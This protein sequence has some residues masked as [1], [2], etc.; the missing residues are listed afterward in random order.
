MNKAFL[1]FF[2]CTISLLTSAQVYNLIVITTDGLRWQEV[3][4]GMDSSLAKNPKYNQRDSAFIFKKYWAESS[5]ERRKKLMP[6][7]WST[8]YESGSIYGNR[9]YQNFVNNK[10][11]YW[12]SYPGYSE[13]FT[14]T[15][16]TSINSN[17][18]PPNHLENLLEFLHK[19]PKYKGKVAAFGAWNAFDRILNQERSGFPVFSAFDSIGGKNPTRN[20]TLINSMM[21]Q[22]YRPF[23]DGEV[24]DVFTHFAAFEYLKTKKPKI[25][26]IAYGDTDEWAHH[27]YYK[28]YLEAAHQVDE[29]LHHL[30]QYIQSDPVYKNKTA[31]FFTTDHGRGDNIKDQWR[32]HGQKIS[33][34]SE[35]YF[36]VMSPQLKAKGEMNSKSQYY[37]SQFAQTMAD[38]IGVKFNPK[39]EVNEKIP[40]EKK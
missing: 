33:D 3:F 32:D 28:S 20:E 15:A 29:W 26:Y 35:I 4:A 14:G 8:V 34:A 1:F 18:F 17:N 16:D 19:L 38:L 9:K 21:Q 36:A 5:D 23:G 22:S 13:I 11:P 31:L 27:G 10:N 2:F 7:L 12:F 40:L 30:W 37:Q 24:L 39:H 25:F 6:F